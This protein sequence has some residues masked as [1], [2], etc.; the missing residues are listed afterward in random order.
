MLL[1]SFCLRRSTLG[2]GI[3]LSGLGAVRGV[4]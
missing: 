4:R 1:F 3:G 2:I